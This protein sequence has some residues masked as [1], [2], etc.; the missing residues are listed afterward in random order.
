[1]ASQAKEVKYYLK[2]LHSGELRHLAFH[3]LQTSDYEKQSAVPFATGWF[4]YST[5]YSTTH[6][7]SSDICI[8][9]QNI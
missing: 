1:M 2:R 6:L 8:Y 3:D 9:L 4:G 7:G 5:G